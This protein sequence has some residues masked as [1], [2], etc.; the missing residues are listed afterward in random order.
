MKTD[1]E[2]ELEYSNNSNL[3][4]NPDSINNNSPELPSLLIFSTFN[5]EIESMREIYEK[6]INEY[7]NKIREL[8]QLVSQQYIKIESLENQLSKNQEILNIEETKNKI[9]ISVINDLENKL[10]MYENK[11]QIYSK[12]GAH[13]N[14]ISIKNKINNE[15]N[16][17]DN[18]EQNMNS[19][20]VNKIYMN[21]RLID[22]NLNNNN[23]SKNNLISNSKKSGSNSNYKLNSN[24]GL[25]PT[26]VTTINK[27][28]INDGKEI[29]N[30]INENINKMMQGNNVNLSNRTGGSLG[31]LDILNDENMNDNDNI[32]LNQEDLK[33]GKYYNALNNQGMENNMKRINSNEDDNELNDNRNIIIDRDTDIHKESI[34]TTGL[35]NLENY[36]DNVIS[37]IDNNINKILPNKS[38]TIQNC[39]SFDLKPMISTNIYNSLYSNDKKGNNQGKKIN[40][41]NNKER[42]LLYLDFFNRCKKDLSMNDYSKFSMIIK[43]TNKKEITKDESYLLIKELLE[44]K[45]E[46]LY[47]IY[48]VIFPSVKGKSM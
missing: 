48:K 39:P 30:K 38:K 9:S 23:S 1:S 34:P 20:E 6:R 29:K 14:S 4:N 8:E 36:I 5:K 44:N 42:G 3:Q 28:M 37:N 16:L 18:N 19:S 2:Q 35:Y 21:N 17:Y 25:N 11:E 24:K 43:K 33:N 27:K 7:E 31:E 40:D 15:N 47:A 45:Y 41:M 22:L 32:R 10:S 46:N 26:I 13:D 12:Y